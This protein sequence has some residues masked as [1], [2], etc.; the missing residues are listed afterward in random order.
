MHEL[1][2]WNLREKYGK[3]IPSTSYITHGIHPYTAKLIPHIP[4]Y[5][6]SKYSK[7]NELVLDGFCGSGTTL[8]EAMLLSRN[9]I[10]IDINPLAILIS[11]VKTTPLDIEET[12]SSIALL[13]KIIKENNQIDCV[14]FPNINHWFCPEAQN[15]LS[16]IRF[17]LLNSENK[18][19]PDI[20]RFFL[21][22]FSS[23]IRKSSNADPR[24]AKTYRS[25][26]ILEKIAKG[27]IPT[28]IKY[29]EEALDRNF[30]K[31]KSFLEVQRLK[32]TYVK[33]F[34]GDAKRTPDILQLNEISTPDLII[35]SP[36]YINA[37]DYF[38]SYKLELY[39][40]G[41]AMPEDIS[42]LRRQT[43]GNDY[44]SGFDRDSIPI[45]TDPVLEKILSKIWNNGQKSSNE[46]SYVVSK[47]FWDMQDVMD[48]LYEVLKPNGY[49]CLI[50]GNNTI[51]GVEIPTYKIL[52]NIADRIGFSLIKVGRDMIM[53]RSLPPRRK[54]IGGIIKEEWITI[55]QKR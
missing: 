12:S 35:T 21:V 53:N 29:F 27:W 26:R 23:I 41:L 48:K 20:Y 33:A 38:R 10:G 11:K 5:L 50:T 2:E 8:L 43:I 45:S 14:K 40:L 34:E 39:W 49:F 22:C 19:D 51:C 42:F 17:C 18:F 44:V 47:Y 52:I 55:F 3:T 46:K 37:Q 30:E 4:R 25:K 24:M 9:A 6:I 31:I 54:H 28:P 15:E 13:K 16:Q 7:E 32:N 36:P 1:E